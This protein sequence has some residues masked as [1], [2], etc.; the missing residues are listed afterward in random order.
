MGEGVWLG[1][2]SSLPRPRADEARVIGDRALRRQINK[3]KA[4]RDIRKKVTWLCEAIGY[5]GRTST[6]GRTDP[7]RQ[8]PKWRSCGPVGEGGFV[9]SDRTYGARRVWRDAAGEW[10]RM[11]PA[12]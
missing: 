6:L 10:R 5:P 8:I 2:R 11:R 3:L 12:P 7:Q 1:S 4:E 9:A